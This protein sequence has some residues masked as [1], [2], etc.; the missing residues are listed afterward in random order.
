MSAKSTA[1]VDYGA[2]DDRATFDESFP[3]DDEV[4]ETELVSK[5]CLIV[6]YSLC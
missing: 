1:G 5:K 6:T 3:D 2:D 4:P